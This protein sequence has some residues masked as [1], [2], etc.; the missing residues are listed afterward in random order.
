MRAARGLLKWSR[1]RLEE[2]STVAARTVLDFES[3]RRMPR[4]V[5]LAAIKAALESGG[6][7]FT[8]GDA[9]G[10]RLTKPPT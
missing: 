6:V 1:E 4:Q 3:G 10:V 9:P 2:A 7:E 8:N 5:T